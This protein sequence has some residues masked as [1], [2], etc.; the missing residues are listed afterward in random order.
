[1]THAKKLAEKNRH[2]KH[3]KAKAHHKETDRLRCA[4]YQ[5]LADKIERTKKHKADGRA[6]KVKGETMPT[7]FCANSKH[8]KNWKHFNGNRGGKPMRGESMKVSII[9]EFP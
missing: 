7:M 3:R 2:R 4:N 9:W 5:G 1:M 6:H 8:A